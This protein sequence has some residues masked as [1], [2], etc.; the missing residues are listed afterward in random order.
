MTN[1]SDKLPALSSLAAFFSNQT[2]DRYLDG[3]WQNQLK[4]QLCWFCNKQSNENA[5]G[6]ERKWL[7]RP[8]VWRAP[9]WSFMA[10]DGVVDF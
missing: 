4:E 8:A 1:P 3:L 9:S 2:G 5:F 7:T 6:P 10:V